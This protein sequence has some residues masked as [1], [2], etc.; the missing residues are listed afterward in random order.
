MPVAWR[1]VKERH[2][3]TAFS[4]E[5]AARVGGRW[6]SRGRRLVYTSATQSLAVLESLVHLDPAMVFRYVMIRAEFPE[7]LV[8]TLAPSV[9]PRG[10][11]DEPPPSAT[12]WIGDQWVRD[13]RSAVLAVPSVIVPGE[14]NYLLN[15][16][17]DDFAKMKQGDPL[18]F[19]IDARLRR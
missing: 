10:W 9:L 19:G 3:T 6:N 11:R 14:I 4:G 13:C 2:A 5:G 7:S 12:K 16:A 1:L 15:P 17:H 8:E 18:P